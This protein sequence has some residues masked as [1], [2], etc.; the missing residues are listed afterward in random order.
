MNRAD[1]V[2]WTEGM[3][4][5]PHHFQQAERWLEGYS[6]SWGKLQC[7]YHWGFMTLSFDPSLLRQGKLAIAEA[8]GMMPDGTPFIISDAENG[9]A[10][11]E[12]GDNQSDIQV[13]L[14][15]PEQRDGRTEVI[16]EA[17]SDSLARYGARESEVADL[18]S[19]AVGRAAVQFGTLRLRLMAASDLNAEWTALGVAHVKGKDASRHLQLDSSYIPPLLNGHS[20]PAVAAFINDLDGI[21]SQRSEQMAQRLQQAGRGGNAEMI[22]FMLLALINRHIGQLSHARRLPQLHPEQ[23]FSDWLQFA[24]EL[25]T[26]SPT[27]R[28]EE[29]PRYDHDNLQLSF[30]RLMLHLRQ[31][32]SLVMEESA[33]QLTLT[34]RSHGLY[35]ATVS[36]ASLLRDYGFV[37]AVRADMPS[38]TLLTHFP[39][40]MKIAPVSRIRDLVQLQ[41]PG[42]ALRAM[43]A[44]PRQI[45]WHAG[46]TYFA[47]EQGGDLWAQMTKSEAFALHLAGEFPGLN[48]QLWALRNAH[49]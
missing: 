26:W 34:E 30:S 3:F 8:S 5:R 47:L 48:L 12:I 4:L 28:P 20:S 46:Y 27:R 16:F 11:L 35:V 24:A 31:R 25:A 40:Q 29:F 10:P 21:L 15:L 1:K 19:A 17:S 6:R 36:D 18:N 7:P 38:E 33:L 42:I 23:L 41:L 43:P 9:P 37:L 2:I 49:D 14:A 22:D 32:L 45:P 44:A 13:V 39:A